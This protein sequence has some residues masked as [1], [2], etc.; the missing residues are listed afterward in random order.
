MYIY[1]NM[2]MHLQNNTTVI[3]LILSKR[4]IKIYKILE[5]KLKKM[6]HKEDTFFKT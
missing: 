2:L 1:I 5:L 3:T 6:E 4:T